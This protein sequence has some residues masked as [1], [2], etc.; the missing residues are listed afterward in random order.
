LPLVPQRGGNHHWIYLSFQPPLA[1]FGCLVELPVM[2]GAK[3]NDKF[4]AHLESDTACLAHMT[5]VRRRSSADGTRLASNER[6][7]SLRRT[8]LGSPIARSLLCKELRCMH[9]RYRAFP[10]AI[11]WGSAAPMGHPAPRRCS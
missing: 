9:S 1:F 6:R 2:N 8:R 11:R 3:R 7:C 5:C 10:A 4:V